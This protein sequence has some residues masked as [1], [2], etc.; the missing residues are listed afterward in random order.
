[1]GR[2]FSRFWMN[3]TDQI[4]IATII[5]GDRLRQVSPS[6]VAQ[7]AESIAMVGLRHPLWC[8]HTDDGP[9]LVSGAHRLEACRSLGWAVVPVMWDDGTLGDD[10]RRL[11]EIDENLI[12]NELSALEQGEH[13]HERQRILDSKGLLAKRGDNRHSRPDKLSGLESRTTEALAAD[14]GL[15]GRTLRRRV[16]VARDIAPD[17]RETVKEL[18]RQDRATVADNQAQLQ[19][20]A[21]EA[22]DAQRAIVSRIASGE[23]KDVHTAKSL[24]R[25]ERRDELRAN[26]LP[27]P[28]KVYRTLVVDPP[29]EMTK[30]KRA[31]FPEQD[32]FDYPQMSIDEIAELDIDSMAA[33]DSHLYLWTTHRWLP[34]C[35]GLVEKWGFR[36]HCLLTWVKPTGFTPF[37]WMF[38][39]ELVLFCRR[40]DLRLDKMGR[41]VDFSAP[42][43]GHSIKPDAFFDLVREVSPGPRIEVFSR[44][45]HEGFDAYGDEASS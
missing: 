14:I 44:A 15:S 26:P 20:L 11:R 22:P 21:K 16:E 35:F 45:G 27:L 37:S 2:R 12:R 43:Q 8:Q 29:W 6:K 7:L 36:Y 9:L 18:R 4:D 32:G 13:F 25:Q 42:A 38:T 30:S 28:D 39:T 33:D 17:V 3:M 40:G 1:M 34:H 41:R 31:N 10:E 5:I 19:V 23:A 24:I